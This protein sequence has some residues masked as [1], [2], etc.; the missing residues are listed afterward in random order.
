MKYKTS[1]KTA[2]AGLAAALALGW[3]AQDALQAQ[4][5]SLQTPPV[6]IT[7]KT[8]F[9]VP[10]ADAQTQAITAAALAFLDGLTPEQRQA[11]I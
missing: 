7:V 8:A 4:G 3:F 6:P 10:E 5:R 1:P 2:A 11:A 9:E